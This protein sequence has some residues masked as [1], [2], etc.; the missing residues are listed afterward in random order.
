MFCIPKTNVNQTTVDTIKLEAKNII[1]QLLGFGVTPD[2]LLEYGVSEDIIAI[3]FSE[4][5]Y[6][7]PS[8]LSYLSSP[9]PL[10]PVPSSTTST[11]SYS[12][13]SSNNLN[14]STAATS[15]FSHSISPRTPNLPLHDPPP[16]PPH[17]SNI[18]STNYLQSTKAGLEMEIQ[19]REELL[20]RKAALSIAN[21]KAAEKAVNFL[22]D[23]F[24]FASTPSTSSADTTIT[25]IN[26]SLSIPSIS[27]SSQ[28]PLHS[29]SLSST[30]SSSLPHNNT[31]SSLLP[32]IKR[33]VAF[34]FETLPIPSTSSF[35]HPIISSTTSRIS[36]FVFSQQEAA[37]SRSLIIDLSDDDDG[38]GS[39]EE[40]EEETDVASTSTF[41]SGSNNNLI[42]PAINSTKTKSPLVTSNSISSLLANATT[43]IIPSSRA[44]SVTI[45][46]TR[47]E[48]LS[49]ERKLLEKEIEIRKVM[50]KIAS[51]EK[52]RSSMVLPFNSTSV[53][54]NDI[55]AIT[56]RENSVSL[57]GSL[58]EKLLNA[59]AIAEE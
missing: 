9:L 14:P 44:P 7:L 12:N 43:S 25:T 38:S 27:S 47:S 17:S 59:R 16:P 54:G 15:N 35:I 55:S 32:D 2:Y 28:S 50:L 31:T 1:S 51:M 53:N 29:P 20:A 39:E 56:S 33:A 49:T 40:I 58:R 57:E 45:S 18:N 10:L 36:T 4:L 11:T 41:S 8:H 23:F 5:G 24:S 26:T 30:T 52:K 21:K 13:N 34:D 48:E 42:T 19:K 3:T 22:D 37:Q 6:R 46:S